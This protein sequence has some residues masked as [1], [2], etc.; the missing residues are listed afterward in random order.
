MPSQTL[1]SPPKSTLEVSDSSS[2]VSLSLS[3]V[4]VQLFI[5][6][7]LLCNPMDCS[8][9]GFPLHNQV[10]KLAQTHVH[11]VSKAIQPSHLLSPSPP[12]FTLSQHQG[13]FQWV[14][15]SHQVAKCW[16]FII[17]PSNDYSGPI[18]FRMDWLD[19][20][21]V[22]GTLK[23]LLQCH[24]LKAAV[25][26]ITI[27]AAENS[28]GEPV[29]SKEKQTSHRALKILLK[30]LS[31]NNLKLIAKIVQDILWTLHQAFYHMYRYV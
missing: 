12:A 16:S 22:Q 6:V 11:W 15:S 31:R 18:S 7:Q 21:A 4:S 30:T 20:L 28:Q 24:S 2:L 8:T 19:L 13:L 1:F 9:P 29:G 3:W 5:H 25:Q 17:S 26:T 23:S 14:S 10:P 27:G